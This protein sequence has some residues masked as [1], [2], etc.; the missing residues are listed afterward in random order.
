MNRNEPGFRRHLG[1]IADAAD[2]ARIAHRHGRE[3]HRPAL[4]DADRH[5]LRRNRL[6]EPE[7]AVDD[8]E[9]RRV[10]EHPDVAIRHDH[11]VLL[12]LHVTR[13]ADHAV[14]V[15]AGEIGG[16]EVTSDALGLGARA[17]G[18]HE[19]VADEVA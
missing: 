12:E 19:N 18:R 6:A 2:M 9:N 16:D 5:R 13:H 14:A 10:E 4:G 17:P 15:V 11:A 8:G 7:L 3:P 1:P